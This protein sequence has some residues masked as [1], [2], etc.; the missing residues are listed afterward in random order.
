MMTN[1]KQKP[2]NAEKK[3]YKSYVGKT[4][5]AVI[6]CP[7]CKKA[8]AISTKDFPQRKT[9]LSVRCPCSNTFKVFLDYRKS[10]RKSTNLVATLRVASGRE[11]LVKISNLS[12]GGAQIEFTGL[13]HFTTGQNGRLDFTLDD[14]KRTQVRKNFSVRNIR[15]K[16]IGCRFKDDQAYDKELGFYLRT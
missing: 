5:R 9:S 11:H 3:V 4:G 12:L 7:K 15:G 13:N 8:K 16:K 10:F 14:K 6:M 1:K 2:Q